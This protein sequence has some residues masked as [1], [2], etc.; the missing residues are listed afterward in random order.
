MTGVL[1]GDTIGKILRRAGHFQEF[2]TA[3]LA[4]ILL[5]V[6]VSQP[7]ASTKI[8]KPELA[9]DFGGEEDK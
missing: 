1:Q 2:V 9:V 4:H 3:Y 7:C 6:A 5:K 8:R